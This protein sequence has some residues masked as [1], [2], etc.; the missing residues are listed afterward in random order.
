MDVDELH[1]EAPHLH[2]HML[3]DVYA[4]AMSS[5]SIHAHTDMWTLPL[6]GQRRVPTVITL[7]G[8]LDTPLAR[9]TLAQY[10]HVPL[11]SISDAQR[12]GVDDLDLTGSATVPHGLDLGHYLE[13]TRTGGGHHALHRTD[14]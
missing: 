14:Q 2:L 4:S 6:R 7:H 11:V 12:A 1:D 8:R 5:T 3:S 10:P 9:R 13:A